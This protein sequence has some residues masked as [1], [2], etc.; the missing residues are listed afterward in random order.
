MY[1]YLYL[2]LKSINIDHMQVKNTHLG[3]GFKDLLFSP[4]FVEDSHSDQHFSDEL[5]PPTSHSRTNPSAFTCSAR[6][7]PRAVPLYDLLRA[8][9]ARDLHKLSH[10]KGAIR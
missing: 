1:T 3:G 6:L 9:T 8:S 5:K 4:L 10:P 7:V 2:Y